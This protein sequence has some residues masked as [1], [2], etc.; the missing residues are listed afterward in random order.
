M[1][2]PGPG[3]GRTPTRSVPEGTRPLTQLFAP[4]D[5]H[6]YEQDADAVFAHLRATEPVHWHEPGGFWC[7]TRQAE[8]R[9]VSRTPNIF[10]SASGLQMWQIPLANAGVDLTPAGVDGAVSILE[11]D[12]PRHHQIRKLVMSA[13]TPR[14]LR[15]LESRITDITKATLDACDPADTIDFVDQ[16]AVPLPMLVIADMIGIPG[17]DATT[18]KRWS[19]SLVEAG[20]GGVTDQTIN[21][22][23]ELFDY[24]TKSLVKHRASP[25]DDIITM[26]QR[27]EIDGEHLTEGEI[28]M[29]LMTLLV[30][31]NETTRNLIA[32]G[33]QV[34]AEHP[35]QR[36]LLAADASLIPGAVEEL[37][38]WLSPVRSF[39]R[40]TVTDTAL[41][42]TPIRA[43]DYVV[44]FYG[45][46]NRDEAV[47]G[48][49][50][51]RFD[52]TRPDANK[53]LAFG[54]GE[55]VCLGA[56]LARIEARIMFEALLDRWPN[57]M[58]DG[59][60]QLH[61]SCLMNG[62]AQLPV[63]LAG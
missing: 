10:S 37:L 24:F 5:P 33:G 54:I 28:L 63:R 51:D 30:A 45:S 60:P 53:H 23:A 32:G 6:F 3:V 16:V 14:Y 38:R 49:T 57:W 46:A 19:D 18:F 15:Q 59:Q 34:L 39:I 40:R 44:M 55:H 56:S 48:N 58:I 31:G 43:G 12:P 42:G 52:V 17:S 26:L 41:A 62:L 61:P 29:F 20:G 8:I 2:R 11:M 21:D 35:D 47:F 36:A 4:Q 22:L 13:F 1:V 25:H 7:L 50:A 9:E 27:A